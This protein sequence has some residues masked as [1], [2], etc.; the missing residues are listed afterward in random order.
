MVFAA[1]SD[2]PDWQRLIAVYG[3][4]LVSSWVAIWAL[5]SAWRRERERGRELSQRLVASATEQAK[6]ASEMSAVLGAA[7][8]YLRDLRDQGTR[9]VTREHPR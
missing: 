4:A 8:E 1:V 5:W 7:N 3:P 6:A 2:L 9:A